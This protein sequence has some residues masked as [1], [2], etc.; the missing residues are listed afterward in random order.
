MYS[1]RIVKIDSKKLEMKTFDKKDQPFYE[2]VIDKSVD[3]GK[4][5]TGTLNSC[6][7]V[8]GWESSM[9]FLK[10]KITYENELI[11]E[12]ITISDFFFCVI[13]NFILKFVIFIVFYV[14]LC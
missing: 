4:L 8:L 1:F 10:Y 12:V 7:G 13:K 5:V 6:G 3:D 11:K 14:F 2:L 9:L